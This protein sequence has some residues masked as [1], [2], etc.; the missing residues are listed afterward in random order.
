MQPMQPLGS[1]PPR[2]DALP[3]IVENIPAALLAF[4][5]FLLWDW[6]LRDGRDGPRWTKPPLRVVGTGYAK[7][8]DAAGWGSFRAAL[9]AYKARKLSGI[10]FALSATD[11]FCFGDVDDCRDPETGAIAEWA[12]PLLARF[13][14][15]Y[16]EISP[17]GTGVKILLR[18]KLPRDEHRLKVGT[19]ALS[20]VEWFDERKYTT[21]TG[22]RLESAAADV[23][24]GQ[25]AL[26]ALY[27]ET[28]A[29]QERATRQPTTINLDDDALIDKARAAKNGGGF[30]ALFDRGDTAPYGNDDSAADLALC[31][32]LAFWVGDDP[33]RIDRVFR[34]SKL[35]RD[36]WDRKDYRD[37]TISKALAGRSEF[38]T[39]PRLTVVPNGAEPPPTDGSREP[40]VPPPPP[41]PE[42]DDAA[43]SGLAGDVV[44]QLAPHTEAD[45]VATLATFLVL[46]GCSCNR[47]P[48]F[49]VGEGRHGTN[50]FAV[51]VGSTGKARKGTSL[52]GPKRLMGMADGGFVAERFVDGLSSGEGLIWQIRD[53]VVK[54]NRKGEQVVE[55]E[56]VQDKRLVCVEE[57]FAGLLGVAERQGNTISPVV[58]RAWDARGILASTTKNSPAKA[59]NPHVSILGH[60]TND[61]LKRTLTDTAIANGLGNRFLWFL[62]RRSKVLA[63]PGRI[64]DDDAAVL[65][66]EIADAL[67]FARGSGEFTQDG[68]A[69]DLWEEIYGPLSEAKPGLGGALMARGEA[70]VLRLSLL[71]AALDRSRSIGAR[72]L[73]SA[74]AVWDYCEKSIVRIFGD[75]SGDP[76]ADRV[77][78]ALRTNGAMTQTALR[79]LF[80]HNVPAGRLASAMETLV[81]LGRVA[82]TQEASNGRGRPVTTWTALP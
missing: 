63:H 48:H 57:E 81:G 74:L 59:S 47:T 37:L 51:L 27:A 46:F 72:H 13:A 50:L 16:Q 40:D 66:A 21:L 78:V 9:A 71:Y 35:M 69:W 44:Y 17:S 32:H 8:T 25:A 61:E 36:K 52:D 73:R 49:Y 34:R 41:W 14:F 3:P 56:A 22:R 30:V 7:S 80:S 82:S 43:L 18:G 68:E 11:P 31:D 23:A 28:K 65:G 77:L 6:E 62:V 55:V 70:Q 76:V 19:D 67:Q 1:A 60:I 38:Y 33:S 58:R 26:D 79:E 42:L 10:G 15:T 53:A 39:P 24:D 64:L 5:Q 54:T 45:D 29:Q 2:P 20:Y 75:V 12:R 4:D